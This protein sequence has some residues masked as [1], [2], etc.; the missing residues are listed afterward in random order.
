MTSSIKTPSK[1][2][3]RACGCAA[4]QRRRSKKSN[5]SRR[6]TAS[7]TAVTTTPRFIP[8]PPATAK[9]IPVD[10]ALTS[11]TT[12]NTTPPIAAQIEASRLVGRVVLIRTVASRSRGYV[13]G[14]RAGGGTRTHG[15]RITNALLYQLSYSGVV[16]N[17]RPENL[18]SSLD[19][20]QPMPKAQSE[21]GTSE[22]NRR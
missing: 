7:A 10:A 1:R 17:G 3:R 13:G 19:T 12:A 20:A 6:S 22:G 2:R 16:R 21:R 4:P 9:L 15:P 11:H 14:L 8:W 5:A 18:L